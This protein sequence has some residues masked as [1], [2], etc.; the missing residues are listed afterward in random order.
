M[1]NI[2]TTIRAK[3]IALV[4]QMIKLEQLKAKGYID[5]DDEHDDY[6]AED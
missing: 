6:N 3:R 2:T 1:T 4:F 5:A